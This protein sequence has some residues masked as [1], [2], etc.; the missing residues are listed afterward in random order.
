MNNYNWDKAFPNTPKSF[1]NK[2]S[3]TL[4]S[5]PDKKENCE[6]ENKKSCKKISIK[7]RF[8]IALAATMVIGTTVFAAGK[9]FT[10]T[11]HG[12]NI[13]TYTAIPTVEQVKKDLEFSP[14]LISKFDNGYT[15]AKGHIVINEGL[16]EKD[17]S[18]AKTKS[19]DFRY[20]KGKDE[21][22]LS[23]D[24]G[25]LGEES[26]NTTVAD[27][28]NGIKL[29]YISYTNKLVPTNYKMTEQDKQDKAS[30][31]YVFSFGSDKEKISQVQNLNWTQDGIYYSFLGMSSDISKDELVKMAKQVIDTK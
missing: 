26:S 25:R 22:F 3:Q 10:V 12:S 11:S 2:V 5:L 30:G 24:N 19:L 1:K 31:K 21:I 6:M 29:N 17:K 16:D 20:T 8:A 18:V 15:F 28:Y 13:P 14:K 23:M 4:N 9:I 7:K 27:T